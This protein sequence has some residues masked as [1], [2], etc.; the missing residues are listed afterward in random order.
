MSYDQA[1]EKNY[2]YGVETNNSLVNST[3][4]YTTLG[5]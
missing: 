2:V 1:L 3:P 5:N 4:D